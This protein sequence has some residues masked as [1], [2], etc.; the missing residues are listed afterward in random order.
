MGVRNQADTC[1]S[2]HSSRILGEGKERGDGWSV[3]TSHKTGR[4]FRLTTETDRLTPR[5]PTREAFDRKS[6]TRLSLLKRKRE[7]KIVLE[8]H[9][10]VSEGDYLIERSKA[11]SSRHATTIVAQQTGREQVSRPPTATKVC[12]DSRPSCLLPMAGV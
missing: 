5:T 10:L 1:S 3:R 6:G 12:R 9:F 8:A 4:S 11:A 7:G 2:S